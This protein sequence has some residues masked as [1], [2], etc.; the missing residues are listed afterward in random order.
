MKNDPEI[1]KILREEERCGKLRN[2]PLSSQFQEDTHPNTTQNNSPITPTGHSP[3]VDPQPSVIDLVSNQEKY[4]TIF[5]NYSV[6]I[7][8]VDNNERIVSWNKYTEELLNMQQQDLY[9]KPVSSL[10]PSEEWQKI[11]KENVRKKGIR[12]QMETQML[13]KNQE[14]LDVDISLCIL[15]GFG[16][17]VVGSVGIIRDIT[18]LKKAEK[19][20]KDSEQR[21]RTIFDNSAVA[22]TLTD[23]NEKIIQW[24]R[25]AEQLFGM[26]NEDLSGKSVQELY[27]A[28]EWQRI[29]AENI[30]QKGMQ[31]HME[32]KI[33]RKDH[34]QID[35]DLSL[36]VLK[37]HEGKVVGS[38]GV[39]KDISEK[40]RAERTL[41]ESEERYRTIF[42][43]SAIAITLSDEN[44]KIISWNKYAEML[45]GMNNDDLFGRPVQDLYPMVEWQKIRGENIRQ[46]GMQHHMETKIQ[47][48]DHEQIDVDL[49]LSVLKNHEGKVVGSI[50]VIKDISE[51]K[52]AEKTLEASEK[53]F[54]LLYEKAP[55]PYH[56]LS[57]TG[58][59]TDVND[60]W[61]QTF[62]YT[63]NEVLNK[64][65]FEFISEKEKKQAQDSFAKKVLAGKVYNGGHEREYRTKTGEPRLFVTHDFFL[66]DENGKVT[67]VY[68]T[69]EDITEMKKAERQ[70]KEKIIELEQYK[71]LTVNREIKMLELKKE[72][73]ELYKKLQMEPKY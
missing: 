49:S 17:E 40:K 26:N 11:R 31:H 8:L 52:R 32:T 2:Q 42:D 28:V 41:K 66:Y 57:P 68:T 70:L 29:R 71:T 38:I 45:L 15:K 34:E 51:K 18:E 13:R 44:E 36:S 25:C 61:C 10:Y 62:G 19:N 12:Y 53:K 33:Q 6:G 55:V 16:G 7:T 54:K 27:P 56:T 58:I 35:V 46:K 5:Q 4:E 60:K 63:R 39:I 48:K 50:G 30:R 22:I 73:N 3:S 64:P 65:I 47:R 14:L 43:N 72:I 21:Y 59:I 20:L 37:N 23:E 24:N 9:L 69:I 67:S 1:I